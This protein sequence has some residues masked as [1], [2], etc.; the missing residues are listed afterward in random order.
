MEHLMGGGGSG[1][2]GVGGNPMDLTFET[3]P[4]DIH[5]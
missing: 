2:G 1:M 5:I 3:Q 4:F